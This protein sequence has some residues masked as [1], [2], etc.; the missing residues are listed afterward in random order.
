MSKD[1]EFSIKDRGFLDGL[2]NKEPDREYIRLKEYR[3]AFFKG[4][5]KYHERKY[6]ITGG[7][8]N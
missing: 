1:K 4:F 6:E 8:N 5:W 2:A 7:N 3:D